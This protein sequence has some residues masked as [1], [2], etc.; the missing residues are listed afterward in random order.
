MKS[1]EDAKSEIEQKLKTQKAVE[2]AVKEGEAKLKQLRE[3]DSTELVWSVPRTVFQRQAQTG[4]DPAIKE[5]FR[6]SA[7]KLP[8]YGGMQSQNGYKLVRV[9]NIIEVGEID[10]DKRKTLSEQL[11]Q[12]VNGEEL[13]AFV[14]GLKNRAKIKINEQALKVHEAGES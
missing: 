12:V 1:F 3:N 10:P 8:V 7:S 2:M 14:E 6:L 9:S 4:D 13:T 11:Q 5:A